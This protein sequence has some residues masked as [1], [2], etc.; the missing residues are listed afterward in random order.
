MFLFTVASREFVPPI[1]TNEITGVFVLPV[2]VSARIP[3]IPQFADTFVGE[4]R[5]F[6]FSAAQ[7]PPR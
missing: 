3:T 2:L 6:T 1:G 4:L 5:P 7:T